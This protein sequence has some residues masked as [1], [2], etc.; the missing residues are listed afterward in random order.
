MTVPDLSIVIATCNRAPL[1]RE[2]LQAIEHT[3][4]CRYEII[5]VNGASTDATPQVLAEF[6]ARYPDRCHIIHETQREGFVRAVNKG[7]RAARGR[8][9]M[10][11]NDDARPLPHAL[12]LAVSQMDAAPPAVGLLALFHHNAVEK[13]VAYQTSCQGR[14]FKLL[15]VRGTLYANFGLARRSTF[16]QLDYFDERYF[17]N[18][19]DPDFALKVWH[20]ELQVVPAWGALIDH[21]EHEDDRR[22]LDTPRAQADNHTLFAKWNLPD[23]NPQQNDFLPYRPCTLRGLR[24]PA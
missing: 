24:V 3:T 16:A 17:L 13:N 6:Q 22:A 8:N 15:H 21:D 11:L 9:L 2:A 10:W 1:L 12:D 4:Q 5:L 7:F 14:Q 20:A 18:A 23:K 19:A